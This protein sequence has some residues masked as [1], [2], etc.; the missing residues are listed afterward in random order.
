MVNQRVAL[1]EIPD[2]LYRVRIAGMKEINFERFTKDNLAEQEFYVDYTNGF[3]YFNVA[4]EA[5]TI[6]IGYKGRGM[7]LYP[8]TRIVHT[9]NTYGTETLH[10]I[11]EK[12]EIKLEELFDKTEDFEELIERVV[13]AVNDSLLA[14]DSANQSALAADQAAELVKDAYET[15]MIIYLPFVG[16]KDDIDVQYPNPKVGWSVQVKDTGIRYR[17]DGQKWIPIDALGGNIVKANEEVDG[18]MSKEHFIKLEDISKQ[19]DV[20]TIVF[21]I[22][23]MLMQG[24]QDAHIVFPFEGVIERIS[25]YVAVTGVEPTPIDLE[26][27]T[28]SKNWQKVTDNPVL[29]PPSSY[30]DNQAHTLLIEKVKKDSIF[31][32]NI[33]TFSADVLNLTLSV[34]IKIN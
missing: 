8:S 24:V 3:V 26:V 22:P 17:Y 19:V 30:K 34:D 7:I 15:T 31:R 21:I 27:S 2:T 11:I 18:L 25:A 29:I 9:D 16:T 32:L 1:L 12:S 14:T 10:Q 23:Q 28:N 4:K 6:S 13:I 5:E 20:R 33:P